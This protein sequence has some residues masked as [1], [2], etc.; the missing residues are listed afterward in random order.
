MLR[1]IHEHTD[2]QPP[3]LSHP[4]ITKQ[5]Q[6]GLT[7]SR[8]PPTQKHTLTHTSY[9]PRHTWPCPRD[10][11]TV[12]RNTD[13][14]KSEVYIHMQA[15]THKPTQSHSAQALAS[16]EIHRSTPAKWAQIQAHSQDTTPYT[17]THFFH[18][19]SSRG[20]CTPIQG[21]QTHTPET[22]VQTPAIYT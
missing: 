7:L 17:H 11:H 13:S 3:V 2:T 4:H 22:L 18:K 12:W 10:G 8:R 6:Q 21:S 1:E 14:D 20:L 9:T 19:E 15:H 16:T 5:T